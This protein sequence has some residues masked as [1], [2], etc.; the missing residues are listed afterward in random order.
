MPLGVRVTPDW[1]AKD[2]ALA[3]EL[4]YAWAQY[5][6]RKG[7]P[8][9]YFDKAAAIAKGLGLRMIMGVNVE[10]CYDAS[11]TPCS[12]EDLV[13]FGT[14]AVSHPESCAF[15]SW[16]YAEGT[17][18][19]AGDSGGVGGAGGGGAGEG[20]GGV[21][22]GGVSGECARSI[23][24]SV[25]FTWP[26]DAQCSMRRRLAKDGRSAWPFCAL[27]LDPQ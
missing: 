11:S 19:T 9:T 26:R 18:A 2:P 6:T 21:R 7:E 3:R 14:I 22:E 1:V 12:A 27:S 25:S 8:E 16:R 13:R 23:L 4:D 17:W 5:A 24:K 10:N 15:I 20:S